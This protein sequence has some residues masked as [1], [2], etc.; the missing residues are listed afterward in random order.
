MGESPQ[1]RAWHASWLAWLDRFQSLSPGEQ[2]AEVATQIPPGGGPWPN[3]ELVAFAES[4]AQLDVELVRDP[5]ALWRVANRPTTK[6]L[7]EIR[8]PVLL[9]EGTG[10]MPGGMSSSPPVDAFATLP[11]VTRVAFDTGHFIRREQFD[12]YMSLVEPFLRQCARM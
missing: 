2:V 8:C 1:Y 10:P 5:A 3:D 9:V 4:Y 11:H 7:E 6:L 12:G